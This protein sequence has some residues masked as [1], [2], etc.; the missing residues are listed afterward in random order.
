MLGRDRCRGL[1]ACS[2][3]SVC[4][5]VLLVNNIWVFPLNA[6]ELHKELV[7]MKTRATA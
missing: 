4:P 7:E 5:M 3:K 2:G 6:V 1:A